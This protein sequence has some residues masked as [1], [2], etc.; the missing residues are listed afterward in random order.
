MRVPALLR[1]RERAVTE[2]D[3]EFLARQALPAKIGRVKCLQPRPAESGNVAPGQTYVLVI[4]RLPQPEGYLDPNQLKLNEDDIVALT[5]YLDERRLLTVR[6]DVRPPAYYWVSVKVQLRPS[7]GVPQA[8]VQSEVLSRLNRFINP[9]TG[10][11]DGKGWQFGRD[12]FV[13]D[14]YQS[15]QGI[16]NVQFIRNVEMYTTQPDG[17]THD[18]PVEYIELVAHGVIASGL[19]TVEFI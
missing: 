6:L 8:E 10:G 3:F 11:P 14:V 5:N 12:L 4:P 7:P 1:S 2:D 9:L 18:S 13:S 16:P 15:L 17:E 19:H